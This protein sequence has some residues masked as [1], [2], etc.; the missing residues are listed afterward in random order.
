MPGAAD[1]P[2]GPGATPSA[3]PPATATATTPHSTTTTTAA[4]AAAATTTTTTAAAAALI[5]RVGVVYLDSLLDSAGVECAAPGV[6]RVVEL[7]CTKQ[8]TQVGSQ[9]NKYAALRGQRSNIEPFANRP[10]L[11]CMQAVKHLPLR[12]PAL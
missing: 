12:V 5:A 7:Q 8:Q 10:V 3:P 2:A 4:A 11:Q 9:K 1:G 6:R